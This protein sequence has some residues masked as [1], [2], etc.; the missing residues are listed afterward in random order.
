MDLKFKIDHRNKKAG[1]RE[2][3]DEED[4]DEEDGNKEVLRVKKARETVVQQ[5]VISPGGQTGWHSHPG[6]VIVLIK[7]GTITFYDGDD[8]TCGARTYTDLA[9]VL[10]NNPNYPDYTSGANNVTGAMTKSLEVFFGT[11]KM[12]FD[13]P[14]TPR[15]STWRDVERF[16]SG[17]QS[18]M[19]AS[20]SASTS[21]SRRR[22]RAAA[23]GEIRHDTSCSAGN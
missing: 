4:R 10:I 6:P 13:V 5:I 7:A 16:S 22:A 2:D 12:T 17:Q 20:C 3:R 11:D 9:A 15:M 1:E 23:S 21:A 19:R 8:P 14:A 18:S